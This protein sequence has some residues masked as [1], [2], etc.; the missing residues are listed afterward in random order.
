ME[1]IGVR[2]HC[3][4]SWSC[5]Y[6]LSCW[7]LWSRRKCAGNEPNMTDDLNRKLS[8]TGLLC[9][10]PAPGADTKH[11]QELADALA[12]EIL[13]SLRSWLHRREPQRF[14]HYD[15]FVASRPVSDPQEWQPIFSQV[16]HLFGDHPSKRPFQ[17]DLG[18]ASQ[19]PTSCAWTRSASIPLKGDYRWTFRSGQEERRYFTMTTRSRWRRRLLIPP[20]SPGSGYGRLLCLRRHQ[21]EVPCGSMPTDIRF[22]NTSPNV[23]VE[24]KRAVAR[25]HINLGHPAPPSRLLRSSFTGHVGSHSKTS[26][27][28]KPAPTATSAT[29]TGY[30]SHDR[31]TTV[32]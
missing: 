7:S 14:G 8:A 25:L 6:D 12:W 18:S 26:M 24:I 32:L 2:G 3:P 31:A 11:S 23:T 17:V 27:F 28:N 21:V 19:W 1:T 4:P 5:Y 13:T 10:K 20:S 16:K 15:A 29:T 9:C 30:D 22:D